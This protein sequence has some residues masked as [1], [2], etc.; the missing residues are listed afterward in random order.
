MNLARQSSVGTGGECIR[1]I[2][3]AGVVTLV[4]AA[5]SASGAGSSPSAG[6]AVQSS[7]VASP[8]AA[9]P[10]RFKS[11]S[12]AASP[13]P[14]ASPI[15]LSKSF[16]SP[17]YGYTV[18]IANGWTAQPATLLADNPKSDDAT[19]T[20]VITVTGTDTTILDVAWNLNGK[21]FSTW[22]TGYWNGMR[23]SVPPGCDGGAP[24]SWPAV[25]VGG[26]QGVWQQKCNAAVATIAHGGKAYQ[27]A[28]END[29]FSGD[30]HLSVED[31]QTVLGTVTF[32]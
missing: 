28:W 19:A 4:L 20:D 24:S 30:Q 14:T 8:S 7:A 18:G 11:P 31:F 10:T 23:T 29:T 16:K 17:I 2:L 13:T 27:F 26:H 5:C 25:T 32:P 15:L 3:L 9:P 22:L 6:A 1:S 12:P 21:P